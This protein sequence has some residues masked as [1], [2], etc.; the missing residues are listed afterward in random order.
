[1]FYFQ[2]LLELGCL[3][4]VHILVEIH[5]SFPQRVHSMQGTSTI[6]TPKDGENGGEGVLGFDNGISFRGRGSTDESLTTQEA[7][8]SFQK[9]L[10]HVTSADSR[11]PTWSPEIEENFWIHCFKTLNIL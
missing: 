5:F 11:E 10:L 1:M 6:M 3:S 7:Q 4:L 2:E 9:D 8:G